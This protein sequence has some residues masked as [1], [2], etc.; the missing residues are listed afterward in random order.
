MNGDS[1]PSAL[2][3][4]D[5]QDARPPVTV[6]LSVRQPWAWLIVNGFKDLE[7]RSW[8]TEFRGRVL[9][10]AGKKYGPD[11]RRDAEVV[12]LEFGIAIPEVLELGGIVGSV[13]IYGCVK[14]SASP[15]FCDGGY[16][17]LLRNPELLP[18]RAMRGQLGFFNV[19]GD[20][21]FALFGK[22]EAL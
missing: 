21:S 18:F 22:E 16:A 5:G 17:F 2:V 9:I 10:H 8:P 15:W 3:D 20:R 11:E 12:R 1:E 13:E 14:E 7:N 19:A 4:G 6:A